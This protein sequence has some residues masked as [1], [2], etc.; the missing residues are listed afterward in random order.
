MENFKNYNEIKLQNINPSSAIS[1]LSWVYNNIEIDISEIKDYLEEIGFK[2][3]K[4]NEDGILTPASEFLSTHIPYKW[5]NDNFTIFFAKEEKV[6]DYKDITVTAYDIDE[7]LLYVNFSLKA[8]N[9]NGYL[10]NYGIINHAQ[11]KYGFELMESFAGAITSLFQKQ[12]EEVF[13]NGKEYYVDERIYFN[14]DFIEVEVNEDTM[15]VDAKEIAVDLYEMYKIE[16][17]DKINY[18]FPILN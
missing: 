4:I 10:I 5:L 15:G 6:M 16:K 13:R 7:I 9:L 11:S 12:P 1:Y 18:V 17:E 3:M 14:I 2:M 8:E